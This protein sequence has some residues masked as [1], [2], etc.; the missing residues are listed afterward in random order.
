MSIMGTCNFW[1]IIRAHVSY[2][3]EEC[4]CIRSASPNIYDTTDLNLYVFYPSESCRSY[5]PTECPVYK[6]TEKAIWL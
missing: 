4:N 6:N 5:V 3:E 1:S 2:N